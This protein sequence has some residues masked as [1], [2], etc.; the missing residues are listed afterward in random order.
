[1]WTLEPKYITWR[2][3]TLGRSSQNLRWSRIWI[4]AVLTTRLRFRS[5]RCV[6]D[7]VC[8]VTEPIVCCTSQ[9]DRTRCTK[10][11]VPAKSW[12][13]HSQAIWSIM[14]LE[15]WISS[16]N[17]GT[18]SLLRFLIFR[19]NRIPISFRSNWDQWV[20]IPP[21]EGARGMFWS[22]FVCVL[23]LVQTHISVSPGAE[24]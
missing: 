7:E 17:C 22:D 13:A 21:G 16:P 8:D 5:E 9:I 6:L 4:T 20:G 14:E 24:L 18:H 10:T 2:G 3:D 19:S 1:M 15:I 23:V 11:E 12:Q